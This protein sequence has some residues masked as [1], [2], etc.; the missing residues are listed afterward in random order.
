MI[1]IVALVVSAGVLVYL[2][3]KGQRG[4]TAESRA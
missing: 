2:S 4:I 3:I 1:A